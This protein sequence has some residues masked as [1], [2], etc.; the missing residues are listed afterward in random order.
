MDFNIASAHEA[1]SEQIPDH[2]AVVFRDRRLTFAD[3]TD[4]SRRL[5]NALTGLGLGIHRERS[6]LAG[7]EI[8]QDTVGLYLRNGNEYLEAM[9]GCFKSRTASFNV[10]YRYV[11]DELGAL[12]ADSGAAAIIYHAEFAP[13]VGA[14]V[15]GLDRRPALIQVSDESGNELLPGAVDY[16]RLLADS[17]AARPDLGWSPD[18]LYIAY[19]GGTTGHPKGVLWRQADIFAGAMGGNDPATGAERSSLDEI[20]EIATGPRVHP[21]VLT[22]PLMHVAG[23]W[24]SFI[25]WFGGNPVVIPPDVTRFDAAGVLDIVEAEQASLVNLV[26]NSM[27]RP[28]LTEI[29]KKRHDLS[30]LRVVSSGGAAMTADVK[31]AL[32][33]HLPKVMIVDT[34]GASESGAAA[35]KVTTAS[36]SASAGDFD[37]SPGSCV[38]DDAL[39]AVLEPG[40]D[41]AGWMARRGRV[42]LGYLGDAAKTAATFPVIDGVR[43][44]VPGDRARIEADGVITLLGR[45]SVCINTGGEKVYVEEVEAALHSHD[46]VADVVVVGRPSEQWGSEVVAIVALHPDAPHR[47]IDDATLVAH[48][49]EHLARYKLPKA[50]VRVESLVRNPNGKADYRWA[51]EIATAAAAG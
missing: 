36:T 32:V 13:L 11:A 6:E 38:L 35:R 2:L 26:G 46:A 9:L 41:E 40:A 19:T 45:D 12:F 10:N 27:A 30:C 25:G 14:V 3:M 33:E 16:E 44:T 22:T 49:A 34:M 47:D 48:A 4:R 7:H 29:E 43:Y 8:G 20:I 21:H 28:L 23:Q 31:A 24:I 42:P 18:D 15:P 5:A 50:I 37:P 51:A 1:I 39:T 17:P